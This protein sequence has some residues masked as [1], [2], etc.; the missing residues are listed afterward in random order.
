[1]AKKTVKMVVKSKPTITLTKK[2]KSPRR[3]VR[4]SRVG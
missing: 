4:P 3:R 2:S 1:M